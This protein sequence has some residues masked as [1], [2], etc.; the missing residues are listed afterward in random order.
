MSLLLSELE[1][2]CG[3]GGEGWVSGG[4]GALRGSVWEDGWGRV[5]G[6]C[7][8]IG[9][10]LEVFFFWLMLGVGRWVSGGGLAVHVVV[11][12]GLAVGWSMMWGSWVARPWVA[13]F[14][15]TASWSQ[16]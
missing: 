7:C 6:Q 1:G 3:G 8:G 2:V 11:W 16:G 9:W 10:G 13:R 4:K 12:S 5:A 14:P 15:V